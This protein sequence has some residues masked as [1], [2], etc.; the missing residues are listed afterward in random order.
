MP[1]P[2]RL[3][4]APISRPAAVLSAAATQAARTADFADRSDQVASSRP[5]ATRSPTKPGP[6]RSCSS[7]HPPRRPDRRDD[8]AAAALAGLLELVQPRAGPT[9]TAVVVIA[10]EQDPAA[11]AGRRTVAHLNA[12]GIAHPARRRADRRR[13]RLGRADR[14]RGRDAAGARPDRPGR[15]GPGRNGK[16]ALA[17]VQRRRR[18]TACR[19]RAAPAHA[20]TCTT[21]A[22]A[23]HQLHAAAGRPGIPRRRRDHHQRTCRPRPQRA[24][25]HAP[26][27]ANRPTR[28]STTT[29]PPGWTSEPTRQT[30]PCSARS[31]LDKPPARRRNGSPSTPS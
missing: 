18:S 16:P 30:E 23:G 24:A 21:A 1:P 5:A 7:P 3:R 27:A 8:A 6:R 31:P 17:G 2:A 26:Q 29:S 11:A 22:T 28:P 4:Y 14:P 10:A 25:R 9:G 19:A 15:K 13:R 20:P 12:D